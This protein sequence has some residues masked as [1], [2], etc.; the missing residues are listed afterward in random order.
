MQKE[1]LD[2]KFVR[3][4][5][6]KDISVSIVEDDQRIRAMLVALF[7][8]EKGFQLKSAHG[9]AED[10]L[11][12]SFD[13]EPQVFI[14]D[15]NLPGMDGVACVS[16][17]RSQCTT[18]QFLMYTINDDDMR[19]FDALKSGAN[20]Y[21]LKSSTPEQIIEALRELTQGGAPMSAP[22][23]RRVVNQ[24]RAVPDQ[25]IALEGLSDRE[26]E[27]LTLLAQGLL[28][29]EIADQMGITTGTVKQHIHRIY[30]KLHVQNR[31]EAV[32]RYYGR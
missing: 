12:Y 11:S 24:F 32:N 7:M 19:V 2:A 9:S 25:V 16:K 8:Q 22:V 21:I 31:T 6:N 17:L 18:S 10:A 15:I 30:T 23:A 26:Q 29:K 14:M 1:Q 5:N 27:T 13:H 28:Y 3:M 20:G 4:N